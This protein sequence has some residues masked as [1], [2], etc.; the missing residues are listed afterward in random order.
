MTITVEQ[1][2]A[3]KPND[4]IYQI[5]KRRHVKD[6]YCV[7][8]IWFKSTPDHIEKAFFCRSRN[9][10]IR[11]RPDQLNNCFLSEKEALE[12]ALKL[13]EGDLVDRNRTEQEWIDYLKDRLNKPEVNHATT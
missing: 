8:N 7:G 4:F 5:E 12:E 3:L 6:I 9:Q 11:L 1:F 13:T 2:K 10:L